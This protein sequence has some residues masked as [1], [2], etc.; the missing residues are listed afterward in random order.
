MESTSPKQDRGTVD[1]EPDLCKGC[2]LCIAMCPSDLLVRSEHLN[3]LGY[4]Y[5]EYVGHGCNGC[6]VCFHACPE[7]GGISVTRFR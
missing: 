6:A 3:R 5:A 7:P 2:G 4:R 1:I